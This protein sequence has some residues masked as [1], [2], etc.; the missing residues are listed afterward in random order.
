MLEGLLTDTLSHLI[1]DL[2]TEACSEIYREYR[3]RSRGQTPSLRGNNLYA[4]VDRCVG[5]IQESGISDAA[6][7]ENRAAVHRFL[8]SREFPN[9]VAGEV[10][11]TILGSGS[12]HGS[13]ALI[14][15]MLRRQGCSA[16]V[17]VEVSRDLTQLIATVIETASLS[18]SIEEYAPRQERM[19]QEAALAMAADIL[20]NRLS[21]QLLLI[22]ELL[23]K[24]N[25]DLP[26]V[27][28]RCNALRNSVSKV[29]SELT[30]PHIDRMPALPID[31]LYVGTQL[32]VPEGRGSANYY[33]PN[34]LGRL[35]SAHPRMVVLGLPGGGKTTLTNYLAYWICKS[36]RTAHLPRLALP[37][38]LREQLVDATIGIGLDIISAIGL[39]A[40]HRYQVGMSEAEIRFLCSRGDM[41]VILDGL[42]ELLNPHDRISLK[43]SVEAFAALYP[44]CPILVTSRVV[45][46][47]QAALDPDSFDVAEIGPLSDTQI[48]AYVEKWF[49]IVENQTELSRSRLRDDFIRESANITDI[50]SNPLL[51]SLLCSSYKSSGSLPRNRP[52]VYAKCARILYDEWDRNRLLRPEL[53]FDARVDGVI[54]H[55]GN[56]IFQNPDY[57]FGVPEPVIVHEAA[58]Y[59]SEWQFNDMVLAERAATEFMRF[60]KGRAWVLSDVGTDKAGVSLFQFT[61]RTFL[62][63]FTAVHLKDNLSEDE[64]RLLILERAA[65]S[66][67]HMVCQILLQL[68]PSKRAGLEDRILADLC[69]SLRNAPTPTDVATALCVRALETMPLKPQTVGDLTD[70]TLSVY[71]VRR[72]QPRRKMPASLERASI[73]LDGERLAVENHLRATATFR[74]RING[75]MRDSSRPRGEL[76]YAADFMVTR[77][78]DPVA[79]RSLIDDDNR[80]RLAGVVGSPAF[81]AWLESSALLFQISGAP[82]R[83][84]EGM[85]VGNLVS[86]TICPVVSPD[87]NR[88]LPN[89]LEI[90]CWAAVWASAMQ[91]EWLENILGNYGAK[92][93]RQVNERRLQGYRPHQLWSGLQD[94]PVA[95]AVAPQFLQTATRCVLA[96]IERSI[97]VCRTAERRNE[98]AASYAAKPWG[99]MSFVANM[100]AARYEVKIDR[101]LRLDGQIAKRAGI[102]D[103]CVP[104]GASVWS[105][106]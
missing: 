38:V 19:R 26:Q 89:G 59:L 12:A 24:E 49:S 8:D 29:H 6:S 97:D 23:D 50:R 85:T 65:D 11:S 98:L 92:A 94:V 58:K 90:S 30:P 15:Q 22:T 14:Q 28:D 36:E 106:L 7:A 93:L 40:A 67:W 56:W 33:V 63:Y 17:A 3:E 86:G 41:L 105:L 70:V 103:W 52:Q 82:A 5:N 47:E 34:D 88:P 21:S 74:T 39:T 99:S 54:Q 57:E 27:E 2:I 83:P 87:G 104:N 78:C 46:Y 61:H 62:E 66:V 4:I 10:A 96:L 60:C 53:N 43:K 25:L 18:L 73:W 72:F 44:S 31:Q 84:Y 64:I 48:A 68:V 20:G 69:D 100:V 13:S 95:P 16:D 51:L 81:E 35:V 101:E 32:V 9:I 77:D 102:A 42:D 45:G 37:I 79:L 80:A 91:S 1:A 75:M 76:A 55:L 71:D